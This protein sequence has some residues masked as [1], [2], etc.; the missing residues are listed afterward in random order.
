[1]TIGELVINLESKEM[2]GRD[3]IDQALG[4]P[5]VISTLVEGLFAKDVRVQYECCGLLGLVSL[6]SPGKLYPYFNSLRDLLHH[7]D[8]LVRA[9]AR[10]ILARIVKV[11]TQHKFDLPM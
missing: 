2:T 9:D 3:L 6:A 1:M 10:N 5:R 8:Q 4:R 11:D 7:P